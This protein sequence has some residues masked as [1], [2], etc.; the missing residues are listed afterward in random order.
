[1]NKITAFQATSAL[2]AA[3]IICST[4]LLAQEQIIPNRYISYPAFL[5]VSKEADQY[6]RNRRITEK[7]FIQMA[8]EKKT[9]VLD[10]R[11]RAKYDLL[12]IQGAKHLNFS[13]FTAASLA[14][15]IPSKDTPSSYLLQ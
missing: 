7:Q 6:R 10:T 3:T 9:L 13:D 2:I 11:S 15:A 12:H 14:K 4:A 5:E 8:Q 1:M